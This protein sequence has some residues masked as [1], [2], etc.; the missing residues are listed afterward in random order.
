[1]N[2]QY[3]IEAYKLN[4]DGQNVGLELTKYADTPETARLIYNDLYGQKQTETGE[5]GEIVVTER[6][7][8]LVRL[9]TLAFKMIDSPSQ[10]F[11]NYQA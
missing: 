2:H 9:Y 6:A 5:D 7:K 1:M 8:Y 11:T 10:Y 3:R 4:E